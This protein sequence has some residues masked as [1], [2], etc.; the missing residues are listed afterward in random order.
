MH[1]H[2]CAAGRYK[3]SAYYTYTHR[4]IRRYRK[5]TYSKQAY[6]RI[7]CMLYV[8]V[9]RKVLLLYHVKGL[10]YMQSATPASTNVWISISSVLC[11]WSCMVL[12]V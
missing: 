10:L 6:V 3:Y 9:P 8:L 11:V 7:Q 5:I 2:C 4:Y 12:C 1:L